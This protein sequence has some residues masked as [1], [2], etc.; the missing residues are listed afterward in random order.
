MTAWTGSN[1]DAG[2]LCIPLVT[3]LDAQGFEPDLAALIRFTPRTRRAFSSAVPP[4]NGND[5]HREQVRRRD[6]RAGRAIRPAGP[7]G[8]PQNRPGPPPWRKK[9][10]CARQGFDRSRRG[11]AVGPLAVR[12]LGPRWFFQREVAAVFEK[13]GR[14]IPVYLYDNADRSG[15][16]NPAHPHPGR[17][18]VEPP[19]WI[20]GIKVPDRA[21]LATTKTPRILTI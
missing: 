7:S 21:V 18:A 13:A 12:D 19:D 20:H 15:P 14:S 1:A 9:T 2:G 16:G 11:W 8:R 4:K 10:R 17:Q 3:P 6:R 5:R